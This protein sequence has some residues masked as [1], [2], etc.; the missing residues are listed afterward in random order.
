MLATRPA[1]MMLAGYPW[2]PYKHFTTCI[3]QNPQALQTERRPVTHRATMKVEH[4]R[5]SKKIQV[6][7]TRSRNYSLPQITHGGGGGL[8]DVNDSRLD[9]YQ[10]YSEPCNHSGAGYRLSKN[11]ACSFMLILC[12]RLSS[13]KLRTHPFVVLFQH[14]KTKKVLNKDRGYEILRT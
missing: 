3:N 4:R 2:L 11:L 14:Q 1:G 6:A 12:H 9:D 8:Q 13:H 10:N 7:L 5:E